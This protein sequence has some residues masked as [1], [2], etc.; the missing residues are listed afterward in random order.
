[1]PA[2]QLPAGRLWSGLGLLTGS[3]LLNGLLFGLAPLL[4]QDRA[5]GVWPEPVPFRAIFRPPPPAPPDKK[6]PPPPEPPPPQAKAPWQPQVAPN[7]PLSPRLDLP[8]LAVEVNP[9]MAAGPALA[10]LPATGHPGAGTLDREPAIAAR[11]PPPY[12]Y[13]ARRRGVQGWVKVRFLVDLHG[14]VKQLV[15]LKAQPPG[16]FEET[17]LRTVAHWRFHPA[18]QGGA[19]Q[20]SWQETVIRF[21]LE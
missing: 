12:P 14:Q 21:E 1:M 5:P 9:R 7:T 2:T 16:Y 15:V 17:V 3:L 10:A 8:S 18:L 20:E 4:S 11:I 13:L 6:P 19:P